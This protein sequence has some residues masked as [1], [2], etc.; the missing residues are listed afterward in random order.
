MIY[1]FTHC[2]VTYV[3]KCPYHPPLPS[4]LP[5]PPLPPLD[6]IDIFHIDC[7]VEDE[8]YTMNLYVST[9]IPII[10]TA[11]VI[12]IEV[13]TLAFVGKAKFKASA[14]RRYLIIFIYF[15]RLA[16]LIFRE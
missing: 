15:G 14:S 6:V 5:P 1:I 2:A 12:V 4:S 11:L 10:L 16:L 7:H 13:V 9:L 8:D 3:V